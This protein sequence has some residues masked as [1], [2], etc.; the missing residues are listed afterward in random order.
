M[1]SDILYDRSRQYR[2]RLNRLEEAVSACTNVGELVDA[3]AQLLYKTDKEY[4]SNHAPQSQRVQYHIQRRLDELGQ[5]FEPYDA[6]QQAISKRMRIDKRL[7]LLEEALE[8]YETKGSAGQIGMGIDAGYA[9]EYIMQDRY[10]TTKP[11]LASRLQ[12]IAQRLARVKHDAC[13]SSSKDMKLTNKPSWRERVKEYGKVAVLG[14]YLCVQSLFLGSSTQQPSLTPLEVAQE[15][16]IERDEAQ[17]EDAADKRLYVHS[18]MIRAI[19]SQ[20]SEPTGLPLA[21]HIPEHTSI[22]AYHRIDVHQ[23]NDRQARYTV[24]P[25]SFRKHLSLLYDHGYKALTLDEYMQGMKTPHDKT[26]LL[27]FDDAHPGQ[28]RMIQDTSD[29]N[30]VVDPDCAVGIM[31]S[32]YKTHPDFGKGAVFFVD[33][34]NTP[35]GQDSLVG[36]KLTWL[37][38]HG[39]DI[40]NHTVQHKRLDR[41]RDDEVFFQIGE[42]YRRLKKHI[43]SDTQRVVSLAYPYSIPPRKDLHEDN[44]RAVFLLSARQGVLLQAIHQVLHLLPAYFCLV[45]H[46]AQASSDLFLP[47]K[48]DSYL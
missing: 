37:L 42:A 32:F 19:S 23:G 27:T 2:G 34:D 45:F 18:D 9:L 4:L 28:F 25:E 26:V 12:Y 6:M 8:Q 48:V 14:A 31:E 46:Q 10:L 11:H 15:M 5:R 24:A 38:A 41:I 33:F 36:M 22:I 35:F 30:W 43:G 20:G 47:A 1:L 44:D 16:R 17:K 40:G 21:L 29:G 13:L 7:D 39:Y 3:Q